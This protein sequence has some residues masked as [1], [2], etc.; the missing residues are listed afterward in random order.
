LRQVYFDTLTHDLDSLR[1]LGAKV[2]WD[3]VILGSD[4]C[5]DMASDDPVSEVESLQLD[6]LDHE[7]VLGG[8]VAR[9]LGLSGR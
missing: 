7:A 1:F 5:F 4:Y 2:G 3:R 8:T 6:E 9:L